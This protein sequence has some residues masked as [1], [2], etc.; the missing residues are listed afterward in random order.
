MVLFDFCV[1]YVIFCEII[2][3]WYGEICVHY[4][5]FCKNYCE[6]VGIGFLFIIVDFVRYTILI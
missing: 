5:I 1:H 4:I 2:L 3:Y 6:F